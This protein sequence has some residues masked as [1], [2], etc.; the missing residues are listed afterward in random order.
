MKSVI[1]V[2]I[3]LHTE[4]EQKEFVLSCEE[5]F[6]RQADICADKILASGS[7]FVTLAGPTCSGKTTASDRI[8]G[9]FVKRGVRLMTV[10]ID[11]FYIE[12][13]KLM[14]RA[15]ERGEAL[16]L[17]S[18]DT[19]YIDRLAECIEQIRERKVAEL[20][21]YNF[22]I[23][24]CDHVESVNSGEYDMVLVEGIQAIYPNVHSLF[25]NHELFAAYIRPFSDVALAGEVFA[26]H[27]LRLARRL[28]RDFAC[29]GAS[30]ELTLE[31]W[32]GVRKN[33]EIHIIPNEGSVDFAINSTMA[34]EPSV[35]RDRLLPL[36]ASV[37][38]DSPYAAR[39]KELA[40]RYQRIPSIPEAFVPANSIFREFIGAAR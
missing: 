14:Q 5:N 33:E 39:A 34:Y 11:D 26:S 28:A 6:W 24:G 37:P 13:S 8:A 20:P 3:P 7:R 36:L 35:I 1:T 2:D 4:K 32:A 30:P 18:P 21:R 12:R 31:L 9:A 25:H 29:R 10:S 23:G 22:K 16:D 38:A 17:D 40:Q 27:E 19:I 15:E